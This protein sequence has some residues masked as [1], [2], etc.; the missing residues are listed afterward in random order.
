[1]FRGNFSSA[2]WPA[3]HDRQTGQ[4]VAWRSWQMGF[5][6]RDLAYIDRC[7]RI[8]ADTWK[9]GW[10]QGDYHTTEERVEGYSL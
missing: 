4:G 2:S 10:M 5:R 3:T 7:M 6:F 8:R 1:M 9:C